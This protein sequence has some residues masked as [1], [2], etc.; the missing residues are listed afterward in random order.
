L[1]IHHLDQLPALA[2]IDPPALGVV[3][4]PASV[5]QDVAGRLV[6]VGVGAILNFAPQVLELPPEILV[7]QVDLAIELQV[8][9]F[10]LSQR[11]EANELRPTVA[12]S[13][14]PESVEG[15]A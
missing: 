9:T 14:L 15:L 4:T 2:A 11:R 5:A 3:A 6:E 8:L 12:V 10:Y 7:R 13:M 1:T